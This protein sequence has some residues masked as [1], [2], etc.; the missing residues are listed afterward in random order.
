[1]WLVFM[2]AVIAVPKA[3]AIKVATLSNMDSTET[4]LRRDRV[5]CLRSVSAGWHHLKVQDL[6]SVF[7]GVD[8]TRDP[9][10]VGAAPARFG[11]LANA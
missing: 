5:T 9:V 4:V 3:A 2:C 6:S 10:S 11:D 7:H 8:K 1:M